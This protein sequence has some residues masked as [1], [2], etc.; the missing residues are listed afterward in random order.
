MPNLKPPITT[1]SSV[2]S[3]R[4]SILKAIPKT[5]NFNPLMTIYLTDTTT[6]HEIQIASW[7]KLCASKL[8][9]AENLGIVVE[10]NL[11]Q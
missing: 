4:E 1:T 3:Y 7:Y 6:P 9:Q 5:S 2:I 8:Q 10:G 11:N